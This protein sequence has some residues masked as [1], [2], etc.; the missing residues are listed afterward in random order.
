MQSCGLQTSWGYGTSTRKRDNSQPKLMH[1]SHA[2]FTCIEGKQRN[3]KEIP[4]FKT[5]NRCLNPFARGQPRCPRNHHTSRFDDT[6]FIDRTHQNLRDVGS[7]QHH[8]GQREQQHLQRL[9]PCRHRAY[10]S[11]RSRHNLSDSRRIRGKTSRTIVAILT[12]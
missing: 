5:W 11:C 12:R 2:H 7:R 3:V 9:Q 1:V 6:Q 10:H 4:T 8:C